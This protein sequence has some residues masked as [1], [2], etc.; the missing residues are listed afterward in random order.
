MILLFGAYPAH[1]QQGFLDNWMA[2]LGNLDLLTMGF[3]DDTT[4][5]PDVGCI[6]NPTSDVL[7]VHCASDNSTISYT[8]R[9]LSG[10]IL[11]TGTMSK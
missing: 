11:K 4:E 2:L 5:K 6:P 10:S 1:L 8:I 3:N 7:F 9:S